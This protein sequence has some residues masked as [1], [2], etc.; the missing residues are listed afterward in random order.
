MSRPAVVRIIVV[1]IALTGRGRDS[2][3]QQPTRT[4]PLASASSK[5]TK[6]RLT[7]DAALATLREKCTP[8][9]SGGTT[10][11]IQGELIFERRCLEKTLASQVARVHSVV[12]I[13]GRQLSA[14]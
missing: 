3:A 5:A 9:P 11:G 4:G 7:W 10:M 6:P 1:A 8:P 12:P 13:D 2:L 14:L